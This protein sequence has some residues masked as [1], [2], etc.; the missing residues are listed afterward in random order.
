M[1]ISDWSSDVCSSD[2]PRKF[3]A[4]Q[5]ILRRV[6]PQDAALDHFR[7]PRSPEHARERDPQQ[8]QRGAF[9]KPRPRDG[10]ALVINSGNRTHRSNPPD[11]PGLDQ[12]RDC[13]AAVRLLFGTVRDTVTGRGEVAG[14]TQ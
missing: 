10:Y 2:L 6:D 1:R 14:D 7:L 5:I 8:E 11:S 4:K 9:G 13:G 3:A 12:R